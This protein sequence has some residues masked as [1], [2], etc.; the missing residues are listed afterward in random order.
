M[1]GTIVVMTTR[2]L[3][4][5]GP[6]THELGLGLMGMSGMYG[7]ADERGRDGGCRISGH[8]G[9]M[10]RVR[11]VVDEGKGEWFP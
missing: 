11:P 10:D 7:Q 6:V 9:R 4:S 3:G 1:R 2:T 8:G 5:T